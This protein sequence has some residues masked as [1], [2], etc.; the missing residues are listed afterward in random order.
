VSKGEFEGMGFSLNTNA[1]ILY[2]RPAAMGS[3]VSN[4][5]NLAIRRTSKP[6]LRHG[7]ANTALFVVVLE[8]TT[9]PRMQLFHKL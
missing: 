3:K 4:Y 5:N 2:K 8:S 9:N 6:K 7:L 1:I